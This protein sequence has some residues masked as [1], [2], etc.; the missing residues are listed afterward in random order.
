LV[1]VLSLIV[2]SFFA[3]RI[4]ELASVINFGALTAFL[5]LHVSVVTY[6]IAKK[7]SKNYVKHLVLPIIGFLIIGY[8]WYNLDDLSKQLGFTWLAIGIVYLVFLKLTN[9]GT[10]LDLGE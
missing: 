4:G 5:F 8:V 9:R 7:K 1:A 6:F 3:N 10:K 2:T